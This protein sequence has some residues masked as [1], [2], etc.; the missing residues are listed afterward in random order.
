M[1]SEVGWLDARPDQGLGEMR[2]K[3]QGSNPKP[4]N[5]ELELKVVVDFDSKP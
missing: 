3:K 5:H 2:F 4:L 1:M